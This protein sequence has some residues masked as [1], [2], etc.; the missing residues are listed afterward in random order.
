MRTLPLSGL[1][2][3]IKRDSLEDASRERGDGLEFPQPAIA[4]NVV[5]H[6]VGIIH[7][8]ELAVHQ[9]AHLVGPF[10]F[11]V[12]LRASGHEPEDRSQSK[13][14]RAGSC[15]AVRATSFSPLTSSDVGFK[16]HVQILSDLQGAIKIDQ[17]QLILGEEDV[18]RVDV[19]V[20]V[21]VSF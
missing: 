18:E 13:L 12:E 10:Q 4:D 20:C 15:E 19:T 21:S 2:H 17:L 9:T 3:Y 1:I 11:V 14:L 16:A 8:G 5:D 6:I 7:R